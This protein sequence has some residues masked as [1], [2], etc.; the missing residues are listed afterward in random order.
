MVKKKSSTIVSKDEQSSVSK[1]SFLSKVWVALVIVALLQLI[2][3]SAYFFFTSRLKQA[4][5]EIKLL[6]AGPIENFVKGSVTLIGKGHLYLI[7]LDDGGFLA[8]SRRCTHLGCTVP[9]VK[10]TKQFECP[11]HASVFNKIGEV[12]KSPATRALDLYKITFDRQNI[13][14]DIS[15]PIRRK[16]FSQDQVVYPKASR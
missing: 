13:K 3:G 6:N 12:L 5:E 16:V 7:R 15:H 4:K 8:V 1:R 10:E 2:G 14:I 11:C 9:W